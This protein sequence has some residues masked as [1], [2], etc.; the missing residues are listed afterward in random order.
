MGRRCKKAAA[1]V[2]V[3][4]LLCPAGVS[5]AETAG[6][7]EVVQPRA[8]DDSDYVVKLSISA[9]VASCTATVTGLAGTS[10]VSITMQLQKYENEKWTSVAE[11]SDSAARSRLTLSESHP[12]Q[13]G[14]YRVYATFTVVRNG[15][16]ET[17]SGTSEQKTCN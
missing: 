12:V 2:L 9:G 3:L 6:Q 5:A 8:E 10:S 16:S 11:W 1:L 15:S 14:T 4:F 17:F 13:T 7:G